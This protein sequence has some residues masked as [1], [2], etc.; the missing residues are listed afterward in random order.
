[1][2]TVCFVGLDEL[3][4]AQLAEGMARARAEGDFTTDSANRQPYD[5]VAPQVCREMAATRRPVELARPRLLQ[6]DEFARHQQVI[7]LGFRN[8][9]GFV[10]LP[11]GIRPSAEV[12]AIDPAGP[13]E[14]Q[15]HWLHGV[16]RGLERRLARLVY[17]LKSPDRECCHS[18]C[19]NCVL[20][21]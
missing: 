17:D 15:A 11:A 2:A 20:D 19:V 12:W 16:R 14:D 9:Q 18:G 1:M 7:V 10:A 4:L 8:P 21:R 3:G 6:P 5:E 13:D